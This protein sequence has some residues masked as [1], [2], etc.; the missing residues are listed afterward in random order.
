MNA[1]ALMNNAWHP[2][3]R[4]MIQVSA[5][6]SRP[7][8]NRPHRSNGPRKRE[9]IAPCGHHENT[10]DELTTELYV[11]ARWM[12]IVPLSV[13]ALFP[14]AYAARF[15]N[16]D[17]YW[18]IQPAPTAD[19]MHR[20]RPSK[21]A[22]APSVP[23]VREAVWHRGHH[24]HQTMVLE[25]CSDICVATPR[26][27]ATSELAAISYPPARWRVKNLSISDKQEHEF[28]AT[29]AESP[30]GALRRGSA[31]SCCLGHGATCRE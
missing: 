12:P 10:D 4:Q 31:H 7:W 29:A 5:V 15:T 22:C 26:R 17:R 21:A 1:S 16:T 23:A 3:C 28:H 6:A 11:V 20:A 2:R 9:H 19:D 13:L 30:G 25:Y 14:S 8:G 27:F 24:G 18:L